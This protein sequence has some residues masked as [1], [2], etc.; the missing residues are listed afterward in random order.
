MKRLATGLA[1]D[2]ERWM[3]AVSAGHAKTP[4][5]SEVLRGGPPGIRTPN[6]LIKSP[7]DAYP[8]SSAAVQNRLEIKQSGAYPS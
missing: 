6:L 5:F 1:T 7:A 2:G 8:C 3:R 4:D